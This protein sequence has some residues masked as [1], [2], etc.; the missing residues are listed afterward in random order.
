MKILIVENDPNP[1]EL[2]AAAFRRERHEVQ[3]AASA[4]AARKA[5]ISGSFDLVLLDLYLGGGPGRA[6][7][8]LA[9]Y[10]NPD[11]KMV[12]VA[13]AA[14]F[15]QARLM[16]LS[17]AVVSALRKPVDI[18]HIMAVCQHVCLSRKAAAAS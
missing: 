11:C 16:G 10:A 8:A 17:P 14:G 6:V 13:G 1:R 5:L 4:Q 7:A 3:E 12:L 2:W 15:S 9:T 18:E